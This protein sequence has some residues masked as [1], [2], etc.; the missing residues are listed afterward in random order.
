MENRTL[1]FYWQNLDIYDRCTKNHSRQIQN[2]LDHEDQCNH[3]SLFFAEH[4]HHCHQC[5]H[6]SSARPRLKWSTAPPLF[7]VQV[8]NA[9]PLAPQKVFLCQLL[10]QR[11][12]SSSEAGAMDSN[13]GSKANR[14]VNFKTIMPAD[15]YSTFCIISVRNYI[16][17]LLMVIWL[18]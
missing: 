3:S 5:C 7:V 18:L 1:Q 10:C 4:C 9:R 14:S 11:W 17:L 8:Y 12:A 2:Y 6:V 16:L 15:L 13:V